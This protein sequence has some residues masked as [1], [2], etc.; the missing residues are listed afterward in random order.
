MHGNADAF[1]A[2]LE[3]TASEAFD[4]TL[5][6]GDLVGYGAAPN[7]VVEQVRQLEGTVY[8]VRGNHDKVVAGI[9]SGEYFNQA[10][11]TAATWTAEELT[12]ENLRYVLELPRGP[13]AVDAD[14]TICHG[15]PLD[16]DAYVFSELDAYEIFSI[17]RSPVTFFGH[18]HVPSVF[19][20]NKGQIQVLALRGQGS[21][22]LQADARYLINP[23]SVG[24]PRDRDA[25]AAYMTYDDEARV[26]RWFRA[27]YPVET[28][29]RRIVEAG[30]PSLLAERLE[31]GV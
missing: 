4:A 26:V 29:Q 28:A 27:E 31:I 18:T 11:R 10:A 7:Q 13:V 19:L 25:R 22:T 14:L 1:A 8:T 6:L 20:T 15:S 9:D 2:V 21:M 24:Q 16:E 23:G 12:S 30:L 17:H 3:Q 5:V